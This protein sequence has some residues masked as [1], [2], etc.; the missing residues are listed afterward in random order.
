MP[1]QSASQDKPIFLLFDGHAVIYRA[2]YALPPL[3]DPSGRI[4]N[5]AFG[6][7][8]ILLAALEE[9]EPEYVA[10]TFDHPKPTFRHKEFKDYKA[11]RPEMPDDLQPQIPLVKE[12]VDALG[13]PRFELEGYE[14]DDLI[15]TVSYYLDHQPEKLGAHQEILNVIV[16]GDKDLLQLV[17]DNTHVWIPGRGQGNDLEYDAPLVEEKMGVRPN[18]VVDM[19]ALMGDSSDNIPGIKG[20]GKKTAVKLLEAHQTLDELFERVTQLQGTGEKDDLLKGALLNRLI[21][22]KDSA[23]MSQELAR[24]NCQAPINIDLDQCRIES[25]DKTQAVEIFKQLEFN[26]LLKMLPKDEFEASVQEA[27]F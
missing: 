2:Y 15:G 10:V 7:S 21:E 16:T 5:A 9:F 27:L 19:K 14:A 26:S 11:H 23:Y 25:Y 12:I 18:Q 20:I 17:D 13:I 24:I 1:S 4:V 22:G 3:T 8:R 6:F